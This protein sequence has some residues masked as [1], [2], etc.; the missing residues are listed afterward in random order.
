MRVPSLAYLL[1][2]AGAVAAV[3]APLTFDNA[4]T[5]IYEA[6]L[7]NKTTTPIRGVLTGKAGPKAMGVRFHLRFWDLPDNEYIQYRLHEG[8]VPSDGNCSN[9]GPL[10]DFYQ[11]GGANNCDVRNP[12]TWPACAI[13]DL[14]GKHG[15]LPHN[16]YMTEYLD[17]FL[18]LNTANPAFFGDKS[19]VMYAPNGTVLN[20]GEFRLLEGSGQPVTVPFIWPSTIHLSST[21]TAAVRAKTT[22]NGGGTLTSAIRAPATPTSTPT[23][24]TNTHAPFNFTA[25]R[26]NLTASIHSHSGAAPIHHQPCLVHPTH[27]SD[28]VLGTG[29]ARYTGL[30]AMMVTDSASASA[31]AAT[32]TAT[33]PA[34]VETAGTSASVSQ[35]G[36]QTKTASAHLRYPSYKH[37]SDSHGAAASVYHGRSGLSGVA[38]AGIGALFVLFC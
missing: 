25:C 22:G 30:A 29:T 12:A 1:A 6:S 38:I 19:L 13:G 11:S 8:S 20:C 33:A 15:P 28:G 4:G 34:D 10:F 7:L 37:N 14:S 36:T 21:S 17:D 9:V 5:V 16:T 18:S 3:N 26:A 27:A 35:S 24:A 2:S 32:A 23:T 31:S